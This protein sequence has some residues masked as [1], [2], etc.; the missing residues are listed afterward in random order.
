MAARLAGEAYP[1]DYS[2][3]MRVIRDALAVVAPAPVVVAE[4]ANTMDN[5]RCVSTKLFPDLVLDC[6]M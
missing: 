1:L 2:T 4:G 6:L 5:A 3:A